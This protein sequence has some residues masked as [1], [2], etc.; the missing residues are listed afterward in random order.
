[1]S[2]SF[3]KN[4]RYLLKIP[5]IQIIEFYTSVEIPKDSAKS[6][7]SSN[8]LIFSSIAPLSIRSATN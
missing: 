7:I 5:F 1:V 6:L 3:D 4:K 2:I 8:L